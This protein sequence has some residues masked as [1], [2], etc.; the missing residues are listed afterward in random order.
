M[1]TD[2]KLV[3]SLFSQLSSP[4]SIPGGDMPGDSLKIENDRLQKAKIILPHLLERITDKI[5]TSP[6][7]KVVVSVCGGSGIGKSGIAAL[8]A[9]ALNRMDIKT[10]VLSGDNYPHRVP[11]VND[12]ERVRRYREYGYKAL[13]SLDNYGQELDSA[14]KALWDRDT[15]ADSTLRNIYPWLATYQDAGAEAL[16]R[17][18]GT[19]EEID[20]FELNNLIAAFRAGTQV[21]RLK[22]MGRD[23]MNL[24]YDPVDFSKTRILLLEW[25]HGNSRYLNGVDI[26]VYLHSSPQETLAG[27]LARNRDCALDSPFV[28][29]VLNIEQ[30]KLFAQAQYSAIL[31]LMNGE[32]VSYATLLKHLDD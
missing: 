10:Y 29:L 7:G 20:F 8:L 31:V 19:P 26:P 17:Y 14:V 3:D 24:W 30:E 28:T 22:R 25:T 2:L 1:I 5:V 21:L 27:R 13:V 15:D 9:Y 16:R 32:V 4:I 23:E 6:T 12:A 18:L 11:P